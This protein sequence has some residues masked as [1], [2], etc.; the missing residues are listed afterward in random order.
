L[1][2]SDIISIRNYFY[3]MEGRLG[4]GGEPKPQT[5]ILQRFEDAVGAIQDSASF[6]R[7]L[8][9]SSRFH[10]YSLG[11]QLLIAFARPDATYVAG[12]HTWPKMGRHVKRGEKGIAIMVPHKRMVEDE[13]GEK[14]PVV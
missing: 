13:E 2:C 5:D 14:V 8:D 9:I 11:N 6:R 7:W 1:Q 3:S 12:Y 10:Q 4:R